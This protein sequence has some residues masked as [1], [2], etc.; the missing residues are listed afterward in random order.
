[1]EVVLQNIGS[2]SSSALELL[3]ADENRHWQS[4]L[5]WDY[6]SIHRYIRDYARQGLVEG[7]ALMRGSTPIGYTYVAIVQDRAMLGN[8]YVQESD[9]A[10]GYEEMLANSI[11]TL[12]QGIR[13]VN[14]IEAQP[15]VFSGADFSKIWSAK[16]CQTY[17]RFY[18]SLPLD[19]VIQPKSRPKGFELR[20]WRGKML[21]DAAKVIFDSYRGTVDAEFASN[22]QALSRCREFIDNLV[23]RQGCGIFL[24]NQSTV[25]F[26]AAAP[27]I[28]LQPASSH[29]SNFS[30]L[31]WPA[32]R[33]WS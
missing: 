24:K 10:K 30:T 7:I 9:W 27:W 16:S 26:T 5:N 25:A 18:L 32:R 13:S 22:F 3:M 20:A 6:R 19:K 29:L 2:V 14:R 12:I 23:N 1:M 33:N 4:L 28:G 11:I 21:A 17:D 31:Y 15:M 8:I